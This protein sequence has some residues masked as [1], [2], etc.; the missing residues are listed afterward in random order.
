VSA[1]I[2]SQ[3]AYHLRRPATQYREKT[4]VK[5]CGRDVA[6][7]LADRDAPAQSGH[8]AVSSPAGGLRINLRHVAGATVAHPVGSL[9]LATY[10]TLRDFL[11]KCASEQP[12]ALLVDLKDL[13][14]PSVHAL[15]VFSVVA[16]RIADWPGVPLLLVAGE[17]TQRSMLADSPIG[18][19]VPVHDSLH[20][21]VS[22]ANDPPV[23]SWAVIELPPSP[24]SARR[25]RHFV[26]MNC[27]RWQVERMIHDAMTIATAFVENT[28]QHTNSAALLRIEL[29]RG[30]LTIAVT[31]DDPRHVVL[32]ERLE[33]GVAPTG[34]L[35]VSG[36]AKTWG[37]A[38]TL[39]GGKTVWANLRLPGPAASFGHEMRN[40]E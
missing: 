15:A 40:G 26:R 3:P 9:D 33:G 27:R 2:F 19:F 30:L 1:E 32:H 8:G 16:L 28:L 4:Q 23:R 38:P 25:A 5:G 29:C 34:L 18:R 36:L 14:M 6:A 12:D 7:S 10:A 22:A 31:D 37:C 20:S 21:A 11:L 17:T 39:M 35:V 13:R 24:V